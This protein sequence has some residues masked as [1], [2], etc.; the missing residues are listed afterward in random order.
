M[1]KTKRVLSLAVCFSLFCAMLF[2]G[3]A[4]NNA[5]FAE[6]G[7]E[8]PVK[9]TLRFSFNNG[10]PDIVYELAEGEEITMPDTPVRE[11]FE[12]A[13]WEY[14]RQGYSRCD[15]STEGYALEEMTDCNTFVGARWI[16]AAADESEYRNGDFIYFGSYPQSEVT[17]TQLISALNGLLSDDDWISYGY[18]TGEALNGYPVYGSMAPS[19]FMRY[20]DKEY[21]GAKYR[22]V[23]F[24][25]A[26]PRSTLNS[27]NAVFSS[28]NYGGFEASTVYWFRYDPILWRIL[29]VDKK[30]IISDIALDAQAFSNCVY[31]N[32]DIENSKFSLFGD[33]DYTNFA[34]LYSSSSL[35][36]WLNTSFYDTA[37]SSGAQK[38]NVLSSD[39]P[40]NP[41]YYAQV[42]Y[43]KP[44][45]YVP[46]TDVAVTDNVW[47][48][49]YSELSEF[50]N[51]FRGD[52]YV[53][54]A[55][56]ASR[57][58]EAQGCILWSDT[59]KCNWFTRT[60]S[61]NS[62]YVH[63]VDY[64]GN[65]GLN[66]FGS[67]DTTELGIRPA[68]KVSQLKF[69]EP[70]E[71]T[72]TYM[73]DGNRIGAERYM[74]GDEINPQIEAP[75]KEGCTFSGWD[76]LP[77]TMPAANVTVNAVWSVNQ[78][79]I[80]FDTDG[81][82]P[83]DPV[84]LDF[85]AAITAPQNPEKEG[86]TFVGWNVQIPETMPAEDLVFTAVWALNQ[87]TLS[88]NT[89]GGTPVDPVTLDF[90]AAI[91]APQNPEKEGYTF[92]G[93]DGQIPETMPAENM[94]FTALYSVNSYDLVLYD[95]DGSVIGR[96]P[97][98]YGDPI[99]MPGGAAK[100]N[101]EFTGWIGELPPAMPAFN[102]SLTA[103]WRMCLKSGT[104]DVA[105]ICPDQTPFVNSD[106][107]L[108]SGELRLITE[109]L[110]S[111]ND[112]IPSAFN[113]REVGGDCYAL[114]KI[115][116][117]DADGAT[118][119]PY[120]AYV[121]VKVPVPDGMDTS[122]NIFIMHF[123]ADGSTERITMADG[124]VWFEDGY[125][126]FTTSSF[127]E[128]G[129]YTSGA[130]SISIKAIERYNGK[131]LDYR[132]TLT[133]YADAPYSPDSSIVWFVNGKRAGSGD[134]LTIKE[135]KAPDY[136]IEAKIIEDGS[137]IFESQAEKISV[138]TGFFARIVALFRSIF[139]K[140]PVI[141]Q[142]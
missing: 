33:P 61:Y 109:K 129:F 114:Y 42:N 78:Y 45:D 73:S 77:E 30:I 91:T 3:G 119:Q 138:N 17:D 31:K 21:D 7:D 130:P 83:I 113:A 22:A 55:A 65:K 90:G 44:S 32:P 126:C 82:L 142:I 135:M 14:N 72:V 80:R 120:G 8:S 20:A 10:D 134:S 41:D 123:K 53:D 37:F 19:D 9:H 51:G 86:Y 111:A 106:S 140:L 46:L 136:T 68:I 84:T 107:S 74:P 70:S 25:F 27:P 104:D 132:S 48:I 38:D 137:V 101:Y 121:T 89:D 76:N 79:T 1:I 97:Y 12:F 57:Y 52:G 28:G 4:F 63:N 103:S 112:K 81:A 49:S 75:Q 117:E 35:R 128:F 2:G 127:S 92:V 62:L 102:L 43:P 64:G 36:E 16:A 23:I 96:I 122:K 94:V 118:V 50:Y 110:P 59:G 85:G 105:V 11:G 5:A 133:L 100:A 139:R 26:R 124:R 24:D 88:F 116:V 69:E 93:W 131:T 34:S 15:R 125:L 6:D 13:F 29:D 54:Y 95:S 18:Y 99:V 39:L 67:A 108:S 47:L 60:P 56:S 66:A 71:Y 58:A 40:E 98:N 141:E 115:T 87:Y